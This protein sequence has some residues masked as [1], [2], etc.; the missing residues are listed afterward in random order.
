MIAMGP[1]WWYVNIGSFNGLE[2][3]GNKQ[4][5]KP[6][7]TRTEFNIAIWCHQDTFWGIMTPYNDIDL[8]QNWLTLFGA[9]PWPEQVE[10][11]VKRHGGYVASL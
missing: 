1:Y 2:P 4:L 5:S 9:K 3:S 6:M 8:I 10:G 11:P 7:S